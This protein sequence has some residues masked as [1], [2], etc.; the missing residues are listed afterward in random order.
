MRGLLADVNA[1][2][3]CNALV[4]VCRSPAWLDIWDGLTLRLFRFADFSLHRETPDSIVWELCQREQLVLVTGNRNAAGD[5]SL[6]TTIQLH[7]T[8]TSLP[9]VTVADMERLLRERVYCI[10]A[11]ERLLEYLFEMD[12]H[13]G[14]GRL[15]IP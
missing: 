3:H 10:R 13:V 7:G 2:A 11:A 6:E 15:F 1:E 8:L 9:V 5:D 14:S 12:R 4:S